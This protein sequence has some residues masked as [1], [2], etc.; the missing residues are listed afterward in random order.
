[1]V[2]SVS[3]TAEKC[4]LYTLWKAD[5]IL[6]KFPL[7]SSKIGCMLNS[8]L[9]HDLPSEI[10]H[11]QNRRNCQCVY[12]T[13]APKVIKTGWSLTEIFQKIKRWAFFAGTQCSDAAA[14]YAQQSLWNGRVSVRLSVCPVD[15]QQQRRVCCWAPLSCTILIL[16]RLRCTWLT[17]G[18]LILRSLSFAENS[19]P[20]I[21]SYSCIHT[22]LIRVIF[23][24]E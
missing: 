14:Q 22:A 17:V 16:P 5:L 2:C 24:D 19:W 23:I 18:R 13:G 3:T 11:K 20:Q 7:L 4:H 15:R 21:H 12:H 10:S 9:L 6:I 8:Q 1:M